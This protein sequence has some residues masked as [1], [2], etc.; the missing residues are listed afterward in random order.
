[1]P[2]SIFDLSAPPSEN[3]VK[4]VAIVLSCAAVLA[5]CAGFGPPDIRPGQTEAEARASLGPNTGRYAMPGGVTRLEYATGP[6][7]R[8]TWMA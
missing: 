4:P 8:T 5:G 1:L 7:G 2:C 6:F 3:A